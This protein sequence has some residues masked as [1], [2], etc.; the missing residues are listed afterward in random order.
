[1]EVAKPKKK[2][3][4]RSGACR[5]SW[6]DPGAKQVCFP[7]DPGPDCRSLTHPWSDRIKV[8]RAMELS[9]QKAAMKIVAIV[10]RDKDHIPPITTSDQ[11]PFPY[12]IA[13]NPKQQQNMERG[14]GSWT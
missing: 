13:V 8:R 7:R 12:R 11:N 10:N 1:V 5:S 6:P 14:F 4:G 9:L 2:S 3:V